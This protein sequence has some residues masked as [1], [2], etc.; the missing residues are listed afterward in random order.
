MTLYASWPIK[1]PLLG[2]PTIIVFPP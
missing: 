2:N 1:A